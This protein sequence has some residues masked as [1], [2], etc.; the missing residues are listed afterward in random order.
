MAATLETRLDPSEIDRETLDRLIAAFSKPGHVSVIEED[1]Q[2]SDIPEALY[3]HV[4]EILRMMSAGR[5][6]VMIPEDEQFTTQAAANFLG[7]S[8]QFLVNMIEKNEIP[9]HRVG[10]HRRIYFRDLLAY[11]KKRDQTRRS[12]LDKLSS[13]VEN[14][15]L[16]F[17]EET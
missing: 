17:P 14:A 5:S 8:R 11:Q 7:V 1:G 9:H 16:Y 15:G 12:A 6:I 3:R 2:R 4:L 10:T 13:E